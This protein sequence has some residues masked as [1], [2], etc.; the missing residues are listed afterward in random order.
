MIK[1]RIE[2]AINDKLSDEDARNVVVII[3]H[4][5]R[6]QKACQARTILVLELTLND[7][8]STVLVKGIG[9]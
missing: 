7:I 1:L 6:G 5:H 3:H 9:R 2:I 8:P 4:L